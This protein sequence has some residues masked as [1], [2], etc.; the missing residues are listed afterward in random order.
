[1]ERNC[2][3]NQSDPCNADL[4]DKLNLQMVQDAGKYNLTI[5]KTI[6]NPQD[7]PVCRI[8]NYRIKENECELY[9][10]RPEVNYID[11]TLIINGV[12]RADA[13][14]YTLK[15]SH[16]DGTESSKYLQVIVE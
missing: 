6:N 15:L 14:N 12:I 8:T 4:G 5:Q 7:D 16:S 2:S 11:G 3:F 10:K 13:G 1:V 9:N